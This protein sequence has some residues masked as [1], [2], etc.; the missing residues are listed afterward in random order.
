[1]W[2]FAAFATTQALAVLLMLVAFA[3]GGGAA[4][5]DAANGLWG[6]LFQAVVRIFVAMRMAGL[7]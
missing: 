6:R 3:F 2:A 1:M 7:C 5:A 4:G